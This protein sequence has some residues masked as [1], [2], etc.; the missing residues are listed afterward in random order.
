MLRR[1]YVRADRRPSN[2]EPVSIGEQLKREF[3]EQRLS[4]ESLLDTIPDEGLDL[5]PAIAG[6]EVERCVLLP[7]DCELLSDSSR[8]LLRWPAPANPSGA[9]LWTRGDAR[10]G[11][12]HLVV[13]DSVQGTSEVPRTLV[14]FGHLQY[15]GIEVLRT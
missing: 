6:S 4:L 3:A 12:A 14:G 5:R 7:C 8:N 11:G 13:A 15:K 2:D 1:R 10:E 9:A